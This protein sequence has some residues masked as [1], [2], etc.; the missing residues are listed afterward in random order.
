MFSLHLAQHHWL[1]LGTGVGLEAWPE[2]KGLYAHL[3]TSHDPARG[4][5]PA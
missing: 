1:Y 3:T 5:W 2:Q 4:Q